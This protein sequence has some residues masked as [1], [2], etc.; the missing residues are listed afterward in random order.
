MCGI[1]GL[2]DFSG[3]LKK[4]NA[5]IE[6]ACNKIIHRGPDESGYYYAPGVVLCHRRLS[7]ID[8]NGGKQPMSSSDEKVTISFNGEI[9]NYSSIRNDLE[10]KG[11]KFHTESD[12]EVLLNAYLEYREEC[13]KLFNGMFAV[14]IWDEESKTLTLARDRMGKKPLYYTHDSDTV[15]FSSELKALYSLNNKQKVID[16]DSL[17]DYFTF[18]YIPTP[19]TIYEGMYKLEPATYLVITK[20]G[21]IKNNYWDINFKADHSISFADARSS[22]KELLENAVHDRLVSDV[23]FGAFLSGGIDSSVVVSIMQKHLSTPV[24]TYSIGFDVAKYNELDDARLI[25]KYIGT[26]H[27]EHT[28]ES[29]CSDIVG[30]FAT[31]YDE[32]FGDS[33]S[34]PTFFVSKL[35]AQEVKM[36]LTGDGG[37]EVFGGYKRYSRHLLN[38]KIKSMLPMAR[39]IEWCLLHSPA[40]IAKKAGRALGRALEDY[41]L[42]YLREVALSSTEMARLIIN[43]TGNSY[44]SFDT[45]GSHF[46]L[47][48]TE[49]NS[50]YYGDMRSYMLDDIL[51]KVDRMSMA[52]SIEVRSPFLDVNLL[53][54]SA[55]LPEKYK[56]S[57]K[58]GKLILRDIA[59]DYVPDEIIYNKKKG[60]GIPLKE[61]FKSDLKEMLIDLINAN[62]SNNILNYNL[63]DRLIAEHAEG[64]HDHSEMLWLTLCFEIWCNEYHNV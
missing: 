11:Y 52:N 26:D 50:I 45:F 53:E 56:T 32:P 5:E 62:R 58:M 47:Q 31:Y 57:T 6:A 35:A 43:N 36:V 17:Q 60:F 33:S 13:F 8:L 15:C 21:I 55:R 14:A 20:S 49:L 44:D 37:D 1:F 34:L 27:T 22:A 2:I 61:W 42:N 38:N 59:K 7:I 12:T 54:Y 19:K 18:G 10:N 48:D 51:V 4:S 46:S 63:I 23:P 39:S 25:S 40:K 29:S 3:Q 24:K 30:E 64:I 41:P 9:Y 28:L 16:Y